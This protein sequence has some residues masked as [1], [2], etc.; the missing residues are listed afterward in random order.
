MRWLL[1][2][3]RIQHAPSIFLVPSLL[4]P[5]QQSS[6]FSTTSSSSYPRDNNRERGVSTQRR[7][8]PRQ[9]LSVSNTPLPKP[10]LD[11]SK[12][13]KVEVDEDHGLWDFF[14]GKDKPM[15]TPEEDFE[16]GRPWSVDELRHK[17]WEDLHSL[18]WVCCKERNRIAT[19]AYERRRLEA[20]YGDYESKRRDIAVRSRVF[21]EL[22]MANCFI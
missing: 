10:V 12:R 9:P 20:G 8:G 15:N 5:T 6:S 13:S 2:S 7:T 18:W 14:H 16:H 22:G 17:S 11:A 1:N 21:Y 3:G 19:E 4:V